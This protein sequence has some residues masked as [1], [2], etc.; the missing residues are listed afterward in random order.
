MNI[1]NRYNQMFLSV[2]AKLKKVLP[3]GIWQIGAKSCRKTA[4][5][6][7]SYYY[8]F[9]Q[10]RY[11]KNVERI[12]KKD[13][14]RVAFFLIHGA[15]WKY[16]GIYKLMEKDRRFD[17]I[18]VVCPYIIYGEENMIRTMDQTYQ[19]FSER[20]Y[21]VV[22]TYDEVTKKWMNV[23]KKVK[24]DIV[25]F[26]NPHNL[27][28]SDYY[29][30]NYLDRLT[31]YV[32]YSFHITYLHEAQYNQMFHNLL[33]KAFYETEFHKKFA[34][35]FSDIKGK[36]VVIT[37]Y[38]GTDTFLDEKYEPKSVWKKKDRKIKRLIWAPHHT[39]EGGGVTL[40]YSNF[41]RYSEFMFEVA[42]KYRNVVQIAFK[43][44]PLLRPKLYKHNDWGPKKTNAYYERWNEMSNGQLNESDYTDLFLTSDAMI[45]DSASFMT[46]YLFINKPVLFMV[47]DDDLINRFNEFGKLSFEMHYHAKTEC[48]IINFI[49]NVVINGKDEMLV[50]RTRFI[51]KYLIP[52]NSKSASQN[53]VDEIVESVF[54]IKRQKQ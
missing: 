9:I 1:K 14:I 54:P 35:E 47:R 28:L 36:N 45:H 10:Y 6:Y 29:I 23:K 30:F 51:Q 7:K 17:P 48:E 22:K 5:F 20:G 41:L 2:K 34:E 53:I 4:K 38:P 49:D 3:V 11:K 52:P 32:Q 25:F 37:G 50:D 19:A 40:D 24:P 46:E 31:C 16:D 44:H 15:I 27:T 26:T 42:E 21:N 18:V 39:I 33:W 43:P 13:N 8:K 12:Q